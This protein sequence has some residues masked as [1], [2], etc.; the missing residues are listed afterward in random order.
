MIPTLI[1]G[2]IVY[3]HYKD[4]LL[5]NSSRRTVQILDQTATGIDN[6]ARSMSMTL[7]AL[8]NDWD[9]LDSLSRWNQST[10]T[11][12]RYSISQEI[13]NYLKRTSNYLTEVNV[14]AFYFE[15]GGFYYYGRVPVQD[16]EAVRESDWYKQTL[17]NSHKVNIIDSLDSISNKNPDKY[18]VSAAL[19]PQNDS[20]SGAVEVIYISTVTNVLDVFENSSD[21]YQVSDILI[22]DNN[23]EIIFSR[24]KSAIGNSYYEI[25]NL[26]E[27]V[28][29]KDRTILETIDREE[30]MITSSE[31]A[32]TGW[33]IFYLTRINDAIAELNVISR[34]AVIFLIIMLCL[35]AIFSVYFL[36]NIV[37][38]IK[39]LILTMKIVEKGNFDTS[40]E[41]KSDDELYQLGNA[42]NGMVKK[43][44]NLID[45]RNL[46]E[47][48]K[49]EAEMEALQ[50]QIN[51][52]FIAN[53]LSTIRFMAMIAKVDN[54]KE[55]TEAFINIVTSSFNRSSRF[56]TIETEICV[57][58]S[59]IYIMQVR[60]GNKFV[61]NFEV[62]DEI[63]SNYVLK[64]LIQPIVEN[65]IVHGLSDSD[66]EGKIDVRFK[67]ENDSLLVEVE[68]NGVGIEED[69][70]QKILNEDQ[71]SKKGF[72]GLGIN[73]VDQRIKLNHG[74][75]FGMSIESVLDSY[76]LFK[77]KLPLIDHIEQTE[78]E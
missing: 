30:Y 27:K 15:D 73:N 24:Q 23:E 29:E 38:P 45:E 9:L 42:F 60:Y 41:V 1:I 3:N 18:Y 52:H 71:R 61:V 6:H 50:A 34:G 2:V 5:E 32:K 78:R 31:I 33:T 28:D 7:S 59:Y 4:I 66:G 56:H 54:I 72:T 69:R 13:D 37:I 40:I 63:K 19:H 8:G 12:T 26:M 10:D 39:N 75:D 21:E 67:K 53:T 44:Q 43:I 14:V 35:F 65:A 11:L 16:E 49:N 51:P 77:I 20:V 57:L 48:E 70:I 46:K 74:D 62:S 17:E 36:R 68:D 76:T 25:A 47:K 55:M 58:E 22:L 64:M